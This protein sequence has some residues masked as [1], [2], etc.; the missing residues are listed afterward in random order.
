M[1][2][3][4]LTHNLEGDDTVDLDINIDTLL[5]T[6][7][8]VGTSQMKFSLKQSSSR[9]ASTG[10]AQLRIRSMQKADAVGYVPVTHELPVV[11][12][13]RVAHVEPALAG[14]DTVLLA[15]S[16]ALPAL[17]KLSERYRA[18][19]PLVTVE[20]TRAGVFRL[21]SRSQLGSVTSAWSNVTRITMLEAEGEDGEQEEDQEEGFLSVTVRS[22]DW[23]NVLQLYQTARKIVVCLKDQSALYVYCFLDPNMHSDGG[24]FSYYISHV[25]ES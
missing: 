21:H 17:V 24:I 25:S 16:D 22:R 3:L 4:F 19:H 18:L 8:S 9:G 2:R 13:A 20:G 12:T 5:R 7:R 6:L 15:V 23:W 10:A 14:P 11:L 1:N